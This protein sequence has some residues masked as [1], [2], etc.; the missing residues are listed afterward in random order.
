MK[1]HGKL[2]WAIAAG[3]IPFLCTGKEPDFIS[4]DQLSILNTCEKDAEI[5]LLIFYEDEKP[6]GDYKIK[7]KARRLRKIRFNDLIDLEAMQMERNFA[8]CIKSN[9]PVVVQFS[10]MNTGAAANSEIA[11]VAFPIE[12]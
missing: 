10:R 12:N 6:V 9:V 3:K 11:T 1:T 7:V 8:C 4:Y 2:N 5:S